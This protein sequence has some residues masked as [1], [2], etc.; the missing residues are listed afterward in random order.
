M[1][2]AANHPAAVLQRTMCCS[3]TK[4]KYVAAPQR[5][6]TET[7]PSGVIFFGAAMVGIVT[8]LVLLALVCEMVPS[9]TVTHIN[10][11]LDL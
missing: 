3:P 9:Q 10:L 4:T 7:Y 11:G 6:S 8:G 2:A 1:C 5:P